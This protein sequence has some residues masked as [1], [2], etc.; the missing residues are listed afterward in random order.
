ML[1]SGAPARRPAL[2]IRLTATT[3]H[4]SRLDGKTHW[5][6]A[7]EFE[8]LPMS[9]ESGPPHLDQ[10]RHRQMNLLIRGTTTQTGLQVSAHLLGGLFET[11]KKVSDAAMKRLKMTRHAVCP[12]WN[13]TIRPRLEQALVR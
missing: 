8:C 9:C 5:D 12:R 11:G 13:Y 10:E 7:P 6:Y 1:V 3:I 4:H 2:A